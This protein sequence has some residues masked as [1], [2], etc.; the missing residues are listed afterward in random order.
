MKNVAVLFSGA[1]DSAFAIYK[2][3]NM[4]FEVKFLVTVIPKNDE[5]YMFHHPNIRWT[6]LQAE[7]IGIPLIT[8]ETK[9]E[10]EKELE[11][12]KEVLESLKPEIEGVVSGALESRYQR[13]RIDKICRQLGLESFSPSWKRSM[14]DYIQEMIAS[15]FENIITAVAAEGLDESWLGRKLDLQVLKDLEKVSRKYGIHKGGEGREYETFVLD[16]PV[17]KKKIKILKARKEWDGVRGVYVI[18]NAELVEKRET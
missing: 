15:G 14:R 11:D 18:E 13:V 17:F 10:K 3:I 1:K 6:K 4:G 7:A 5:S 2:A 16:G 12:L 9:G 8:K